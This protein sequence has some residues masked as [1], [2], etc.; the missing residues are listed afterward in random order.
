MPEKPT[1]RL[2]KKPRMNAR[3]LADYMAA[4]ERARRTIVRG[5][6]FRPIARLIQHDRAKNAITRFFFASRADRD[7]L[8]QEAEQLRG[9]LADSDFDRDLY[10]NNADYLDAFAASH[11]A[12]RL[13][14]AELYREERAGDIVLNGV[15]IN[16]DV[17]FALRRVTRTNKIKTG[18]VT[19]RYAKGKV[20]ADEVAA[21]QSSFLFGYRG[22]LDASEQAE[23]E[24]KLCLTI[25]AVAGVAHPAPGDALSRFKNMEAA[26]QSIAER[27]DSI[28]PPDGAVS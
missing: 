16:P 19:F 13:P 23:P 10:D 6:K 24:G 15:T 11:G 22:I 8:T 2:V 21:W 12:L 25:D 1:H 4:S 20:L 17:R 28:E 5:C 7:F 3:Y 26:C 18:F 27:W 9:M 14:E